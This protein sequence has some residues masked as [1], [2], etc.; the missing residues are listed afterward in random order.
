MSR[1]TS[2]SSAG[3]AATSEHGVFAASRLTLAR[4]RRGLTRRELAAVCEVVPDA[5]TKF[6]M[7]RCR[8]LPET[9]QRF[10][11][12]LHF[13]LAWFY[14]SEVQLL[15]SKALS[16]RARRSM[17]AAL[18]DQ[19]TRAGDVVLS[20]VLPELRR[21]FVLPPVQLPDYAGYD[22]EEAARLLRHEW[23]LGQGPI[24]NMVHL[25]ETKGVNV[26]WVREESPTLDAW[27]LWQ[28]SVP[29]V[30]LNLR[31]EAGCRARFDA[32][33]ELGHL[34]LHRGARTL[35]GLEIEA[36]ANHFA[37]AFLL[38]GEQFKAEAPPYPVL[39]A[40][41]PLKRRW[42]VSIAAMVMRCKQLGVFSEW[43]TRRAFQEIATRGWKTQEPEEVALMRETSR[44]QTMLGERLRAKGV[45]V[46]ELARELS[47][48]PSDVRE[49][50]PFLEPMP[51]AQE[52]GAAKDRTARA[53]E[54][55]STTGSLG[56]EVPGSTARHLRL[57]L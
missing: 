13:P 36:E 32:A 31:S 16:F 39:K 26:F 11:L 44:L 37:S 46:E 50:M 43:D 25:L 38:P 35:D 42:G 3:A 40:F 34:V 20:V 24:G 29:L 28:D 49:L 9:V 12:A 27:S 51:L 47:L 10:S 5:I 1:P 17:T 19:T 48:V 18:R 45:D 56:K 30:M 7:Q 4:E 2:P 8:P 54:E 55:P 52:G 14:A 15:D 33:H 41:F 23:K 22:P 6:E 57:V 21:R 53:A